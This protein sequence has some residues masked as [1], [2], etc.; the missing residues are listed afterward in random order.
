MSV[1]SLLYRR[2]PSNSAP[3]DLYK[4]DICT[5]TYL[6]FSDDVPLNGKSLHGNLNCTIYPFS[7]ESRKFYIP[8]IANLTM[9]AYATEIKKSRFADI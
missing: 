9:I 4:A 7:C 2:T 8:L 3:G 6:F 5:L 1:P